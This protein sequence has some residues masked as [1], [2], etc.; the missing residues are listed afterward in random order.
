MRRSIFKAGVWTAFGLLIAIAI[1][2]ANSNAR[3]ADTAA[4]ATQEVVATPASSDDCTPSDACCI[5]ET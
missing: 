1:V 3:H 2:G 5:E 4:K